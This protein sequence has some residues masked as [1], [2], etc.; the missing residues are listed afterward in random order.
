MVSNDEL[1]DLVEKAINRGAVIIVEYDLDVYFSEGRKLVETVQVKNNWM[2]IGP[3]PMSAI[4][5]AEKLRQK[6]HL[7]KEEL[8]KPLYLKTW[9]E[10]GSKVGFA[11]E[12]YDTRS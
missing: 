7:H 3:H 11:S 5:A 10:D 8:T 4:F 6:L 2:G 9:N 12:Y 1:K